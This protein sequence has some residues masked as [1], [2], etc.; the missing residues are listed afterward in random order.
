MV[1]IISLLTVIILLIL[2]LVRSYTREYLL[3]YKVKHY[4]ER[5]KGAGIMDDIKNLKSVLEIKE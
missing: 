5:L 3:N 4:Q 2:L 1:T